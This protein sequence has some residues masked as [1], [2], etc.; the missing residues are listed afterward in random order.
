MENFYAKAYLYCENDLFDLGYFINYNLETLLDSF[1]E[2]KKYLEKKISE[3]NALFKYKSIPGINDRQAQIIQKFVNNPNLVL[4]CKDLEIPL[5]ASPKTI[6]SDLSKLT[7][8]GLL[9]KV[10]KNK[11]LVGYARS[12]DFEKLLKSL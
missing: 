10:A 2:L 4:T 1:N 11:R 9:I 12:D 6:R 5:N 7:D 3:D 8:S